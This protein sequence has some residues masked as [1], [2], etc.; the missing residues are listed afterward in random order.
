[1]SDLYRNATS[2]GPLPQRHSVFRWKVQGR[3]LWMYSSFGLRLYVKRFRGTGLGVRK[4]Q[5]SGDGSSEEREKARF[6]CQCQTMNFYKRS[7]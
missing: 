1:M 7:L 4:V 6:P 5:D 2:K 3:D